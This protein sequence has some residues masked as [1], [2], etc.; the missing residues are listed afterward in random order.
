MRSRVRRLVL[1]GSIAVAPL[2]PSAARADGPAGDD[3]R[4]RAD[5]E[6]AEG[7]LLMD[8][9]QTA[10][11]CDRF[12]QSQRLDPRLGRLLNL[13]FCHELEG[14]TASAWREYNDAMALADQK[15]QAEREDFA[16]EH[17]A[18]IA[19]KLSF[20]RFDIPD[21]A[22]ALEVDGAWIARDRWATPMPLDPGEHKIV[23]GASNKTTRRAVVVVDATPGMQLVAVAPLDEGSST[24]AG[25]AP[26]VA[27]PPSSVSVEAEAP[28]AARPGS[29]HAGAAHLPAYIAGGVAAAGL[30]AGAVFGLV[31][32]AK[33]GDA[34]ARCPGMACDAAGWSLVSDAKAAATASTISFGVAAIGGA[35]AAGL[36]VLAPGRSARAARFTTV[37]GPRMAGIDLQGA[38]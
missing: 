35:L 7:K 23:V 38:W 1:V 18:A 12:A 20:V 33:K 28:H 10:L 26:A 8:S 9:G 13:A 15:G 34:D 11:A 4:A 17:A 37:A 19:K 3:F 24:V 27:P 5:A 31:A 29:P 25:A 6:F 16:R 22:A 36:Y 30:V 32:L 14:K 21:N 2:A